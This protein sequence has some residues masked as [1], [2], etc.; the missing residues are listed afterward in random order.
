MLI[1]QYTRVWIPD[2]DEVWCSAELTKDY[3]EG[4]KSLQL[5]LEDESVCAGRGRGEHGLC[6]QGWWCMVTAVSPM[7]SHLVLSITHMKVVNHGT[8]PRMPHKE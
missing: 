3:K 5:R 2:P 6:C 7:P 1:F 4:E 8:A